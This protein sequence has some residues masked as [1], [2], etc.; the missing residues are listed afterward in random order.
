M[1]LREARERH[2]HEQILA[3]SRDA[4]Q[5]ALADAVERIASFRY[6]GQGHLTAADAF[7]AASAAARAR[8]QRSLARQELHSVTLTT[9]ATNVAGAADQRWASERREVAAWR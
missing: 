1:A 3:R 8:E 4:A 9:R 7:L 6:V 5:R 2:V